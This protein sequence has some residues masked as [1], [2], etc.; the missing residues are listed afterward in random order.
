MAAVLAFCSIKGGNGKTTLGF[1]MAERAA[2]SGAGVILFDCDY[3][4]ASLGLAM[5]REDH[6]GECWPVR[7]REVS[8]A[9][10]ESVRS[11]AEGGY[12]LAICDLPGSESMMLGGF[13]SA[14]DLVLAPVGV[15]AINV[16]AA[17]NLLDL[18]KGLRSPV[19][20]AFVPNNFPRG[21]ARLAALIE[22]LESRGGEVCPAAVQSRVMHLDMFYDGMGVCERFPGSPAALEIDALW[23]WTARRLGLDAF[24][25]A[26]GADG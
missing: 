17:S 7:R 24:I 5:A 6:L 21:R 4:E 16:M 22:E 26:G 15:G 3:Q 19:R 13:L 14:M 11:A 1:N 18:A 10:A 20:M 8:L 2:A 23:R 9:A 25:V 12:D